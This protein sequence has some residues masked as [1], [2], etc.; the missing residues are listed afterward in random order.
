MTL[1]SAGPSGC[2]V[3]TRL[4]KSPSKPSVL[5]VEAGGDNKDAAYLV[6]GDRFNLAFSLPHLNWGYKTAPQTHLK[7]QE[8]DYSRGKG[9]GGSTAINFSCW[10][11]GADEDY[12]EWARKLG[13][14][15]W[16]WKSVK[17]RFKKIENYHVEIP[18]EHQKFISPKAEGEYPVIRLSSGYLLTIQI[19]EPGV[20]ST[21]AML[22]S[23][24]RVFQM[25]SSPLRRLD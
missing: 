22:I 2:A 16:N 12:D 25:C 4:A 10:L 8:I 15:A 14:D 13:D 24:R 17:E 19:M 23:G 5:L 1:H 11:I 9:L 21:S 20:H 18:K 6:P 7:G 3:A